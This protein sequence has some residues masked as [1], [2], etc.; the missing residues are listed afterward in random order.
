MVIHYHKNVRTNVLACMFYYAYIYSNPTILSATSNRVKCFTHVL[1]AT[2]LKSTKIDQVFYQ[3]KFWSLES[4][5][6]L[7]KKTNYRDHA[8]NNLVQFYHQLIKFS[9]VKSLDFKMKVFKFKQ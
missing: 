6:S 1:F 2:L 3:H 4:K 8:K 7:V 9:N 5:R